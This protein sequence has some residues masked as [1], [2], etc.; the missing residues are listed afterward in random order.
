MS[1]GYCVNLY[2]LFMGATTTLSVVFG[3]ILIYKWS[4]NGKS[5]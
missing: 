3:I 5:M 4:N 2:S 1:S